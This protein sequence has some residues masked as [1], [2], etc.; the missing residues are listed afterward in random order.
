M[1]DKL[2]VG[3]VQYPIVG[4]L[5]Y[6]NFVDKV[7]SFVE[8]AR[9]ENA[10]LLVFPELFVADLFQFSDGTAEN[11]R[12]E[13]TRIA[14]EITPEL[15][16]QLKRISQNSNLAILAGST[17]R[18]EKDGIY[19]TSTLI[20]PSGQTA[21]Q[22]KSFLTFSEKVDWKLKPGNSQRIFE[23]PWGQTTIA[24]CYDIEMPC[25]TN[26]LTQGRPELILVPSCTGS[27]YGFDRVR[28][29]ARARAV[30]HFSYVV[31]TSTVG[32]GTNT[33]NMNTH[34]GQA[35]LLTPS[36]EGF[37]GVIS[38]G[39][40]GKSE[41]VIGSLD[42]RILREHRVTTKIYPSREQSDHMPELEIIK[43]PN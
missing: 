31:H 9:T 40:L 1:K 37:P 12:N 4:G 10:E 16:L 24:I 38:Q 27:Q 32:I 21:N 26:L 42:L 3:A 29:C 30:E 18:M 41:I 36:D 33:V 23:T 20:L 15:L 11:E 25:I 39:E 13:I 17:F 7:V 28:C 22:D 14:R 8:R 34:Y 19:N 5:S 43:A 6:R 2:V 35:A